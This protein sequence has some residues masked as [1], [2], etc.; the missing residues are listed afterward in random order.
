MMGLMCTRLVRIHVVLLLC[1]GRSVRPIARKI[2][3]ETVA[4]HKGMLAVIVV[5]C[6]VKI[7]VV[8]GGGRILG[9]HRVLEVGIVVGRP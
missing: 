9:A 4:W 3:G 6:I 7:V 1:H 5:I 8:I 2:G